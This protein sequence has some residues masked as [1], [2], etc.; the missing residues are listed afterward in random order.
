MT[1]LE[2]EKSTTIREDIMKTN[3]YISNIQNVV[4]QLRTDEIAILD[5]SFNHWSH[6]SRPFCI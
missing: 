6:D 5:E 2:S 1:D 3:N 4:H